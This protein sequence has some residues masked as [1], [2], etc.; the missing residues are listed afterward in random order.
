[1]VLRLL[2][3]CEWDGHI[4]KAGTELSIPSAV[5]IEMIQD[6]VAVPVQRP[7]SRQVIKPEEQRH[8]RPTDSR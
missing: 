1:M 2:V 6:Q 4:Y 5:G 3:S 7:V 8:E